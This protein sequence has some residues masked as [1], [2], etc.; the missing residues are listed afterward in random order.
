[1]RPIFTIHAGEYLVGTKIEQ[2]FPGLR[3]W[4]PSKDTG[5]DLLVTDAQHN[6]IASLQVK[7]SKDYLATDKRSV[8]TPEVESGG[9]WTLQRDKIQDSPADLWV[10]VLYQFHTRRFDFVIIPPR[11]LVVR[12]DAIGVRSKT[13]QSYIWVTKHGTC[14]ET[15]GLRQHDLRKVCDGTYENF[16]RDLTPFLNAWPFPGLQPQ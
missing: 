13:I 4:I 2:S 10:M 12:Y 14:W 5:V 7:F 8:V 6:N 1:M 3:V 15:R 9:W 16:D 11:E